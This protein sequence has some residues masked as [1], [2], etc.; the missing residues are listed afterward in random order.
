MVY[1]LGIG[2]IIKTRSNLPFTSVVCVDIPDT[3][4]ESLMMKVK[5][6]IKKEEEKEKTDPQ[7]SH[8]VDPKKPKMPPMGMSHGMGSATPQ[9]IVI[10]SLADFLWGIPEEKQTK[11]PSFGFSVNEKDE[12][13][14]KVKRVLP[15]T[16]AAEKGIKRGDV[17]LSIDGKNFLKMADLKKHLHFKNWNDSTK[18]EVLR[19]EGK[20]EI[21]FVIEPKEEQ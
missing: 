7:K 4:E 13:G 21:E 2:N 18:F 16:I 20:I 5:K 6:S 14:F 3:V 11:Y 19:E 17:I 10:A 9:K 8:E 15:E 1:N 12:K